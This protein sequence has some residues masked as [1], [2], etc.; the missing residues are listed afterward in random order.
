MP[1][2]IPR[3]VRRRVWR[4]ARRL[5]HLQPGWVDKIDLKRFNLESGGNCILGQINPPANGKIPYYRGAIVDLGL[6]LGD[7][8]YNNA[9]DDNYTEMGETGSD[10]GD[11]PDHA[12]WD[13]MDGC[14]EATQL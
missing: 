1:E 4:A 9:G 8:G 3:T 5:D 13:A 10:S 11:M 7:A 6:S 2:V 12:G 14:G